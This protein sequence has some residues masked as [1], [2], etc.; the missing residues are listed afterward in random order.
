MRVLSVLLLAL[1]MLSS[2]CIDCS[3]NPFD[4][5]ACASY[6][7]VYAWAMASGW[8]NE[9]EL[10]A[11]FEDIGIPIESLGEGYLMARDATHDVEL[12]FDGQPGGNATFKPFRVSVSFTTTEP[13]DL[14]EGKARER[15]QRDWPSV[16]PDYERIVDRLE[17]AGITTDEPTIQGAISVP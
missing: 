14:P 1:P 11:A 3:G 9:T 17:S 10:R 5:E 7:G 8:T 15:A 13:V 2:G 4:N 16:Q 12:A 6:T